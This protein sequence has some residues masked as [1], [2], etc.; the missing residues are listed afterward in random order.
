M[1]SQEEDTESV[2]ER[3]ERLESMMDGDD[4]E[5]EGVGQDSGNSR[6]G[7]G[8]WML[9][10]GAFL[11]VG[12]CVFLVCT[13]VPVYKWL[14]ADSWTAVECEILHSGFTMK[15]RYTW[16]GREHVSQLY[17][18]SLS[19]TNT[20]ESEYEAYTEGQTAQCFVN[21]DDP[22][23]AVLSRAFSS[24]YL[25]GLVGLPFALVGLALMLSTGAPGLL[26]MR[27]WITGADLA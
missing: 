20:S 19:N 18:F 16:E 3:R 13:A 11:L 2:E 12:A 24:S 21:P 17:D 26:R 10:S 27:R 5:P 4:D 9:F 1:T 25:L 7:C 8:C 23:E 14:G 22:E 15:Y 6:G